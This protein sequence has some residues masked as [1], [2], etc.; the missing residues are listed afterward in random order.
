M[1]TLNPVDAVMAKHRRKLCLSALI[2]LPIFTGVWFAMYYSLVGIWPAW[3]LIGSGISFFIMALG[4]AS[5]LD[6]QQQQKKC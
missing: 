4:V 5:L 3:A 6:H 1:E 2:S